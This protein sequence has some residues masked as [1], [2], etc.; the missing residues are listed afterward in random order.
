MTWK[1]FCSDSGSKS[2]QIGFEKKEIKKQEIKT[3]EV[4]SQVVVPT[5]DEI[6]VEEKNTIDPDETFVEEKSVVVEKNVEE[7]VSVETNG[8]STIY[9][10]NRVYDE[11]SKILELNIVP[12][13]LKLF[14]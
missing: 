5:I 12:E 13:Q 3:Q 2:V 14:G 7:N 4:H 8:E 10:T 1:T 9:E 6:I 11:N